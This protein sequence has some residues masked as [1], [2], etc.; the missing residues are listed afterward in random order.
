MELKNGP[1][2][3]LRLISISL[4]AANQ[5]FGS[6]I[7]AG[8]WTTLFCM[9][10]SGIVFLAG[11]VS[12]LLPTILTLPLSLVFG[13]IGILFPM[14]LIQ[15]L[16]AK[17]EKTGMTASQALT[18][19]IVPAFYSIISSIILAVPTVVVFLAACFSKSVLVISLVYVAS[20][21]IF[22]PFMFLQQALVLRQQGPIEAL[23]YSWELG[24]TFYVRI[25]LIFASIIA[26]IAIF[27]LGVFCIVKAAK[28]EWMQ[29][30][31]ST[32]Q[33]PQEM[34]PIYLAS[35]LTMIPK[36]LL[37]TGAIVGAALYVF[38]FLTAEAFL[39]AL[40]IN[41]DY[42]ING[43]YSR[44]SDG[45]ILQEQVF[46]APVQTPV[47]PA[48][49]VQPQQVDV[50]HSAI[51]TESVD[52]NTVRHLEQVYNPQEHLDRAIDQDEDRMPTILFDEDMMKQLAE[53]EKQMRERK[54][55]AQ[56]RDDDTPDSIKMS[57]KT[58]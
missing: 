16:A 53:N 38:I 47:A 58:L 26:A 33:I 2:S 21:F 6:T 1:V 3:V 31:L 44:E 11:F 46:S 15:I 12:P 14:A 22:L 20:F 27:I 32:S 4:K 54:E 23:R 9:L 7:A 49:T 45:A 5:A 35:Y 28:P 39:T 17:I 10:L 36:P 13:F 25:L 48:V 55:R 24:K 51:Q 19:S 30:I 56:Q 29:F 37:I 43:A 57:D 52:E 34:L 18:S 50:K 41:L 42:C 8:I 40:F